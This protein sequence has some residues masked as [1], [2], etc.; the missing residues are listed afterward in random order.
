MTVTSKQKEDLP[1]LTLYV[2]EQL[3]SPCAGE[4]FKSTGF[5]TLRA[6]VSDYAVWDQIVEKL[7]G[8]VIYTVN[9]LTGAVIQ[10][11]QRR[12]NRAEKQAMETMEQARARVDEL[13]A[14]L[15]FMERDNENLK[16]QLA[17]AL[18]EK[19]ELQEVV[20]VQDQVLDAR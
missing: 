3:L 2:R 20:D 17:Q 16:G 14:S 18:K 9:D 11:A 8:M 1:G 13:E 10:A 15:S 12:A 4:T 19:Q 6:E 7:D 5:I